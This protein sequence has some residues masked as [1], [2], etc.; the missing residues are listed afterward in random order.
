VKLIYKHSLETNEKML[1]ADIG[2][3]SGCIA[4]SVKTIFPAFEIW[5]IDKS[6][7]ALEVA[8]INATKLNATILLE[9]ND[10]LND[11]DDEMLPVFDII[12]SNP[13]YIPLKD[14]SELEPVVL[15]HEP[16][17][18]LFV[19]DEDPLEFYKGI[20]SFSNNHLTR[21]GM[22]FFETQ[23]LTFLSKQSKVGNCPI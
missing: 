14:K 7:G 1:L 9:K 3:G 19:T 20:L 23:V 12:V 2:T 16:H 6:E 13:P 5:G 15:N 17:L 8:S 22:I 4:I 21:G 18:A 10:I 11:A